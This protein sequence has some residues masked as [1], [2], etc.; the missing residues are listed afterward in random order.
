MVML[1]QTPQMQLLMRRGIPVLVLAEVKV[2]VHPARRL[3][4][5]V[6][7]RWCEARRQYPAAEGATRGMQMR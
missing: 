1:L 7:H 4:M 5:L 2:S 6:G 3:S